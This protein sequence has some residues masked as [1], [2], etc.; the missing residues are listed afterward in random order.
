VLC[1]QVASKNWNIIG[2]RIGAGRLRGGPRGAIC[3]DLFFGLK[4]CGACGVVR[5]SE[6]TPASNH[7]HLSCTLAGKEKKTISN[8]EVISFRGKIVFSAHKSTSNNLL[9]FLRL[10]KCNYE[11]RA[12]QT[13]STLT[14]FIV[15]SISIYVS[16]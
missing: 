7:F 4:K 8:L 9:Y 10:K 11:K 13:T 1:W 2:Q 5:K 6:W 12:S 14:K 16:K 15:N 3:L